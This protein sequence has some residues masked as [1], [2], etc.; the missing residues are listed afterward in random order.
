VGVK[1]LIHGA[2]HYGWIRMSVDFT[3]PVDHPPTVT[4][5][6]YGYETVANQPIKAGSKPTAAVASGSHPEKKPTQPSL[7]ALALGIDGLAIWRR[8]ETLSTM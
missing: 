8:E 1:F 7:G 4:I 2:T 3:A 6:A 5:T